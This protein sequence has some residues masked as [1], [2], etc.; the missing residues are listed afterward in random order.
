MTC[1]IRSI[2]NSEMDTAVN[3]FRNDKHNRDLITIANIFTFKQIH[4]LRNVTISYLSGILISAKLVLHATS[5][6]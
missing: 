3:A 2:L 6:A 4:P 1:N 5:D